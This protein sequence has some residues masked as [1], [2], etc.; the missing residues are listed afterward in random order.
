MDTGHVTENASTAKEIT[1]SILFLRLLP[2]SNLL[3]FTENLCKNY[4]NYF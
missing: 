2:G 1:R 3:I 4:Q